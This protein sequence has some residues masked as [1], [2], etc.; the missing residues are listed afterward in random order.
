M[1][2]D[3]GENEFTYRIHNF[4]WVGAITGHWPD[5]KHGGGHVVGGSSLLSIYCTCLR[6]YQNKHR[7]VRE[8]NCS[9]NHIF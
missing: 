3:Q 8:C 2:A 6:C 7:H 9:P 4:L 5:V 1:N